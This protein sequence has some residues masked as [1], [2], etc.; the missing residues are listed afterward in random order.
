LVARFRIAPRQ[1]MWARG[2]TPFFE[3]LKALQPTHVLVVSKR[4][5]HHLP[6]HGSQ[7]GR[8]P[9]DGTSQESCLVSH[10][11]GQS[12]ATYDPHP[13]ARGGLSMPQ[14]HPMLAVFLNTPPTSASV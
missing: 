5:W 10:E 2:V 7:H 4:L 13:S 8:L 12:L 14:W 6:H 3:V 11:R 9:Y 1:D